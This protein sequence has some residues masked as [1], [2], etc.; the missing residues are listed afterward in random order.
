VEYCPVGDVARWVDTVEALIA[1]REHSPARWFARRQ[2]G[3]ARARSFSWVQFG[4]GI[5]DIYLE[6]GA[7]DT[8]ARARAS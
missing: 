7:A 8:A 3:R 4:A 2:A 5:T 1:E 6:L